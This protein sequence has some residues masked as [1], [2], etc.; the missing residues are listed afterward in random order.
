LSA[1]DRTAAWRT[2]SRSRWFWSRSRESSATCSRSAC[3]CRT[4]V[5]L[6]RRTIPASAS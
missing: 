2:R 5:S 4:I 6:P 1:V 3:C